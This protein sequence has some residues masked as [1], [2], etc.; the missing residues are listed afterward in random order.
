MLELRHTRIVPIADESLGVRSMSLY[1][2]TPDAR[3][4]FDAGVSL[5]PLRYGLPP[6]PE[7]FRALR[8]ARERILEY[9][10]KADIITISHYHRDHFTPPYASLYECTEEDTFL[11]VYSG[12]TIL[13]KSPNFKVSFNQ[14]KRAHGLFKALETAKAG[15]R[16]IFIDSERVKLGDTLVEGFPAVH[17]DNRLGHVACFKVSV[18]GEGVLIFL[19]DVQGPVSEE[20]LRVLLMERFEAAVIGGPPT[21]LEQKR[22]GERATRGLLN[23]AKALGVDRINVVSHHLLRDP[24]WRSLLEGYAPGAK[25]LLYSDILGRVCTLLEAY[26]KLL[27]ET[28]PPPPSYLESLKKRTVKCS[29]F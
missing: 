9:A 17:G 5:G 1:V 22:E 21:Y 7:E 19:P 13:A 10:E 24:E 14:R 16:V 4:L 29:D 27:Y 26:R 20:A 8:A 11:A 18:E 15:S 12:K 2:E 28:D 6:H 3:I 25:V 23:L